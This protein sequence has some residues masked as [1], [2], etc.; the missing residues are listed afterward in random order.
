MVN[1]STHLDTHI[2]TNRSRV[3]HL[4]GEGMRDKDI[5]AML[6]ISRQR[7]AQLRTVQGLERIS[8][9]WA[10]PQERVCISQREGIHTFISTAYAHM[11]CDAH[12]HHVNVCTIC[13]KNYR[14]NGTTTTCH[15][16]RNRANAVRQRIR[17]NLGKGQAHVSS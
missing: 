10:Y 9:A 13:S 1:E 6:G 12:S 3:A 8:P 11:R 14:T 17:N 2:I 16:C 7:V 5:S 4:V 15:P